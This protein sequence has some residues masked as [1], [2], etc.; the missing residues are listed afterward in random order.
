MLRRARALVL[1]TLIVAIAPAPG[2]RSATSY[3]VTSWTDC[4]A[5]SGGT[6]G[7]ADTKGVV[8][9]ACG[10]RLYINDHGTTRRVSLGVSVTDVAPSPDGAH[11]YG[12]SSG[13]VL[14][15]DRQPNGSY[16]RDPSWKLDTFTQ[17]TII[18]TPYGKQLHTDAW[19]DIYLSNSLGPSPNAILK[20]D[21]NGRL[22]T[23]FGA[24]TDTRE[25][26]RFRQN[27][28]VATSRDGST[29]FVIDK[30]DARLQRFDRTSDGSY[31]YAK[32]WGG[33][34]DVNCA[35]GKF[36]APNDV[37]VDAWNTV[38]V[39]DTSC[40]RVQVFDGDGNLLGQAALGKRAHRFAISGEGATYVGEA[41]KKV[42]PNPARTG[43]WPQVAPPPVG[44]FDVQPVTA[45][46]LTGP[47]IWTNGSGQAGPD[48]TMFIACRYSVYVADRNGAFV[49]R[50]PLPTGYKYYDVAPSPDNAYLYVTRVEEF[51]GTQSTPYGQPHTIR[52]VRQG[53]AGWTYTVDPTWK[54]GDFS[55]A[56]KS[57]HPFGRY[58][59][60]DVWGDIYFSNGGWVYHWADDG[61]YSLD[62]PAVNA[63]VKYSAAGTV[64]TMFLSY[65]L[66]DFGANM[67]VTVTRDGRT[68]YT[69]EHALGRIQRWDYDAATGG[70][71]QG[72]V[73]SVKSWGLSDD[74]SLPACL[75]GDGMLSF[76]YDV[77]VDPWDVV[78]VVDTACS[79]VES[80]D[81]NGTFLSATAV[82]A[83]AHGLAVDLHGNVWVAYGGQ[84]LVR[85]ATNPEPGPLPVPE[86][87]PTAPP[88][89][90]DTIAPT[91]ESVT[92]PAIT[93]TQAIDIAVGAADN[94]AVTGMRLA[95]EDGEWAAWQAYTPTVRWTLSP[96]FGVKAVFVQVRDAA[97]N[98]SAEVLKYTS[99]QA[100]VDTADPVITAVTVPAIVHAADPL[101]A[102]VPVAIEV[103]DDTGA[104][105]VRFADESGDYGAW[106]A[107]A[108]TVNVS[109]SPG[110][111]SKAIFVQVRDDAGHWSNEALRFYSLQP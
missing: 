1:G 58:L 52:M 30:A 90:R 24:Y 61:T 40:Q 9:A 102:T 85:S 13:A 28:G 66:G 99:H 98:L 5:N 51:H 12:T 54:L 80:F 36:A 101:T 7:Q 14:R 96:G 50:I 3:T 110:Y 15:F 33:L 67:G 107:F 26:G 56:T 109:T 89:D 77:A 68:I 59:A 34:D 55:T 71:R 91:L 87:L 25:P 47:E 100:I 111:G 19:G 79:K 38:Y 20:Y 86:P 63:I 81:A 41:S 18:Y 10:S 22:K 83:Q 4:V 42:A 8:Y 72:V 16:V 70:Y 31:A 65:N 95:N 49:A 39:L 57:W 60:T 105:E 45:C 17:A 84:R 104:T 76:P 23:M 53:T 78:H 62:E 6:G 108:P 48:G 103:T 106:Q 64:K 74:P 73:S 21:P 82:N 32:E 27:M 93:T 44:S 43:I 46:P 88:T 94:V 35:P 29:V 97:G 69:V 11:V 75:P 2:A 92:V 37:G